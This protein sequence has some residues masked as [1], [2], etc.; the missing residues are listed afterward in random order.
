MFIALANGDV[1]FEE[2]IT[3]GK[4]VDVE[5]TATPATFDVVFR[6]TANGIIFGVGSNNYNYVLCY[7]ILQLLHSIA[8]THS[9]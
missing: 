8:F 7:N 1:V 4:S 3:E 9:T 2:R 5:L 6:Q